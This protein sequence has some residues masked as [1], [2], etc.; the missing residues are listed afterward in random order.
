[1]VP[2]A[3]PLEPGLWQRLRDDIVAGQADVHRGALDVRATR[4]AMVADL[5]DHRHGADVVLAYRAAYSDYVQAGQVQADAQRLLARMN[6][7]G[8]RDTGS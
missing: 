8:A 2:P 4:A 5:A 1:M 3:A 7:P 6:V